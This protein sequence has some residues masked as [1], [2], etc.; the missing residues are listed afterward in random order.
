[1]LTDHKIAYKNALQAYI[2]RLQRAEQTEE[3]SLSTEKVTEKAVEKTTASK[4]PSKPRK[5][6]STASEET[7]RQE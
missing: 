4:S 1:R 6:T 5:S 2:S 3:A 7:P